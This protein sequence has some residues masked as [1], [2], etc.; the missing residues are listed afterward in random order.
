[1]DAI[2]KKILSYLQ[3]DAAIQL[4]DLANKVNLSKTPCWRRIQKM[5]KDGIIRRRVVLVDPR[6]VGKGLI[7]FVYVKT[8]KHNAN[9]LAE[10]ATVVATFPEVLEFYRLSGEWDYFIKVSVSDTSDYDLFYKKL[11]LNADLENVTSS[12]AM[13]EIKHS[14]A[15]PI[16]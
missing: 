16:D 1:M 6:K 11:V 8:N 3:D 14:T 5:E 4:S 2:D 12:F 15:I 10:F 7:V 9:W 13:E